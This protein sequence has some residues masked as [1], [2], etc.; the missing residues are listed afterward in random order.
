MSDAAPLTEPEFMVI[1]VARYVGLGMDLQAARSLA[2]NDW[3]CWGGITAD[4]RA[5]QARTR[6]KARRL[7]RRYE[8]TADDL[9][10]QEFEWDRHSPENQRWYE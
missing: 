7:Q 3:Q 9:A 1:E 5:A 4:M 2:A 6:L 8:P 10:D